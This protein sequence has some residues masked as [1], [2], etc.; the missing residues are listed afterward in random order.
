MPSSRSCAGKAAARAALRRIDALRA[1][2]WTRPDSLARLQALHEFRYRR[3][4]QRAGATDGDD[5]NLEERS[6]AYQRTVRDLLDTQ[7]RELV[8]LRDDGEI[9]DEVMDAITRE[10]DLEDQRLEI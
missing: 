9:S 1:E 10:L 4:A 2:D 8:R 3:M 6:Q 7:R 5:E